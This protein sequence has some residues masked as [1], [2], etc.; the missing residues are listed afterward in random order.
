MKKNKQRHQAIVTQPIV[1]LGMFPVSFPQ[2]GQG[3]PSPPPLFP[4]TVMIVGPCW[5]GGGAYMG[6]GA[7]IMGCPYILNYDMIIQI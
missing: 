5:A 6:W 3:D 1:F 4:P 7:I 2:A